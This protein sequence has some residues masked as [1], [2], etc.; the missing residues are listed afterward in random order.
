[1]LQAHSAAAGDYAGEPLPNRDR[2]TSNTVERGF[3]K[4][5]I[6]QLLGRYAGRSLVDTDE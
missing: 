1:M 6:N 5:G 3:E 4:D 2:V